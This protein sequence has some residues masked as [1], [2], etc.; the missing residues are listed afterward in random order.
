MRL[1]RP[2]RNTLGGYV[3]FIVTWAA[4]WYISVL[5][6]AALAVPVFYFEWFGDTARAV[7]EATL[8]TL[9]AAPVVV[10]FTWTAKKVAD[11]FCKEHKSDSG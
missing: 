8:V 7:L 9:F 5:S 11:Y 1:K 10:A 3:Y 6:C 4:A 2:D